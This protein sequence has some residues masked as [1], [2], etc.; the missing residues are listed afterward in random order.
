MIRALALS[1][2]LACPAG[3]RVLDGQI[4]AQ[5][6][7]GRFVLLDEPPLAVGEDIFDSPDLIA[8]DEAQGVVLSVALRLD[9]GAPIS[10]GTVV[11]L[12]SVVFDGTGGRQRGWVLFDAPILGVATTPATLAATDPLSGVPTLWLGHEMRG[13]E[14]GDRAWIDADD[15]RRLWVDWAGSSPGDHLRVIT[16]AAPMM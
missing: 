13:L 15:P 2:L 11:A 7:A 5:D 16:Q 6:G 1:A 3:A 8:F 4:V 9:I 12:H 14:P 10:T